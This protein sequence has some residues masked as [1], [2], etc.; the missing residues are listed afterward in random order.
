MARNASLCGNIV[1]RA[2]FEHFNFQQRL[3]PRLPWRG[4][5]IVSFCKV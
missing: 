1:I 4:V 2:S 3:A 5:P